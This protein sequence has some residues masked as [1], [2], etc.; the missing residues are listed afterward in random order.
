MRNT[1]PLTHDELVEDA[2]T[3]LRSLSRRFPEALAELVLRPDEEIESV[4]WLETQVA[5]RQLRMD[6]VLRVRLIGGEQ[7]LVH[8]EWTDRLNR[9]V[10][11]R[12]GEYHLSVAVAERI[13]T[14][15]AGNFGEHP[16]D[17]R[18]IESIVVVLRGRK[19][20]WPNVGTYRTTPSDTH[21]GGAWFHI[22]PVYQ[23]TVAELEA[24]RSVFWLAFVPVAV[25]VDEEKLTRILVRL[26]N[27][28]A[29]EDF[30]ELVATMLAVCGLKKDSHRF[31]SVIR[32]C[33]SKEVRMHPFIRWGIE[34][35]V[36]QGITQGITQGIAQERTRSLSLLQRIFERRL[37]RTLTD[38]ERQRIHKR[39]DKD[40]PDAIGDIIVDLSSEQLAVWLAPRSK[41]VG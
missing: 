10:E 28:L 15:S 5:V 3:A 27:E 33:A 17:P 22:E 37:G 38:K 24:R 32:S 19:K 41:R 21:F 36:E 39:I 4:E 34:Q 23:R 26:R 7:R 20:R 18:P 16:R 13:D 11:R 30:D 6:R 35:G 14:E 8:G 25:D 40:G 31:I 12:V 9:R 1:Q 2:D 29:R